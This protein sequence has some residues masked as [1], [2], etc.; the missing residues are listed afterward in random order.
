MT[1]TPFRKL[2]DD[3]KDAVEGEVTLPA[4]AEPADPRDAMRERAECCGKELEALLLKHRCRIV[5]FLTPP[6]PVGTDG[7]RAMIGASFG[8]YADE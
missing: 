8:I 7:S 2:S 6:E 1:D 4:G 5:P 3:G